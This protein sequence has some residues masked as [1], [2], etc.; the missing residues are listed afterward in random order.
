[1]ANIGD[2]Q[3]NLKTGADSELYFS[4][5][6]TTK[7]SSDYGKIIT[8]SGRYRY[9]FLT[10]MTGES[11]K[12]SNETL[13]SNELKK[14][15]VP[16]KKKLGNEMS[17]GSLD[18]EFS[19]T[20][21]DDLIAAALMGKWKTWVSDKNSEI[22]LDKIHCNDGEFL[23]RA[24]VELGKDNYGNW[25]GK[26]NTKEIFEPRKL[27]NDGEE[28]N[29]NG[30]ISVPKGCVVHELTCGSDDIK[31]DV[32]R[33]LGGHED[34]DL[35]QRY[36]NLAVNTMSADIQIGSIVTGSFSF[37]GSNN[38]V[39]V[40]ESSIRKEYGSN[41]SSQF[42]TEGVTGNSF[43]DGL[44]DQSTDTDQFT[45]MEGNLWINGKNV[46]TATNLSMEINNNLE[47]KNAIFVKKAISTTSPRLDISGSLSSYVVFGETEELYNLAAQNK[48][49]EIMFML[50]DKEVNPEYLY[51][52]QIFESSFESPDAGSGQDAIEDSYSYSS[53]NERALRILRITLPRPNGIEFKGAE[54]WTDAGTITVIPNAELASAED[55][56]SYSIKS[57]LK[58]AD[59]TEVATQTITSGATVVD[60]CLVVPESA[61][62]DTTDGVLREIEVVFNDKVDYSLKLTFEQDD[63]APSEVTELTSSVNNSKIALSWTDPTGD[64]IKELA[65]TVTHEVEG[66]PVE[67]I[68]EKVNK[69]V[70][71]YT[72]RRL[73]AGT[74]TV[75]LQTVDAS[76]NKSAGE[77]IEVVIS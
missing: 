23:T 17:E 73:L 40:D 70:Q 38:P 12:G 58:K 39:R 35:Y 71:S 50:Q 76:G 20:T 63:V 44:P 19:P 31:F 66:Q 36:K 49:N 26:Y 21:F 2:I 59:G 11:L 14:G 3:H 16:S 62:S 28:G 1:M 5:V 34:E 67:D 61:F 64:D 45:S 30:L 18:V 60:G 42:V 55:L 22:N 65:V 6:V 48:T 41:E 51:L 69:G 54:T 56:S 52:F 47:R 13:E 53:F 32:L 74:Y 15:K 72:T 46:T 8:K 9:P 75:K 33:H 57:T 29:E 4:Q 43:V 37:M 25:G 10:R 24:I 77:T 27:L 7:S 68:Y